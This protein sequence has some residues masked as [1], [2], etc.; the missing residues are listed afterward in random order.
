M[1]LC[2]VNWG[3]KAFFLDIQKAYDSVWYDGLRYKL[4][5]MGLKER[6]W[7]VIKRMYE[8]SKSAVLSEEEKSDAFIVE[9]GVA[10]DCYLSLFYFWYSLMI[11]TRS[12]A[13]WA[14]DTVKVMK[15]AGGMLCADNFVGISDSKEILQKLI[16]VTTR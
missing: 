16:N 13:G 6:M 15:R 10:Q 11:I 3:E 14:W 2:N 5:G 9:Q 4:W 7:H 8:S 12:G 1:K